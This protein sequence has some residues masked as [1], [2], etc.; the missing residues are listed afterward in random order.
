V[1]SVEDLEERVLR[2]AAAADEHQGPSGL[3]LTGKIEAI[4]RRSRGAY[5]SPNIHAE[6]ADDHQLTGHVR[7]FINPIL[8]G[9]RGTWHPT[10]WNWE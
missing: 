7:T 9:T 10:T 1:P 8:S 6:L 2:L 5:G 3:W 4:H